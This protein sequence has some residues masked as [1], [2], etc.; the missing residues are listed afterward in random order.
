VSL[1]FLQPLL[2]WGAGLIAVPVVIHLLNRRR[3]VV[4][5]FAAMAFLEQAFARRRRRMRTENLLLLLLRCLVLLAAALA[6]ALPQAG[7][8]SPLAL[9]SGGRRELVLIVD[10]SGS[11][12][13]RLPG[14]TSVEGRLLELARAELSGLSDERGDAVTLV[15]PGGA[16]LLPAAIG[17]T[18]GQALATL[19]AGLPGPGGVAD[20]LGAVRLV[21]DRVRPLRPGH[22]DMVVLSD[23]QEVSWREDMG[24]LFQEIMDNGGGSLRVVDVAADAGNTANLGVVSLETDERLVLVGKPATFAAVV[25]N[26]GDSVRPAVSGSFLL[27]GELVRRVTLDPLPPRGTGVA[28]LRLRI[29]S[30]GPHHVTFALDDDELL[31]DDRRSLALHVRP[32]ISVLLVDGSHGASRLDRATG[33]LELALDPGVVGL[34]GDDLFSTGFT[35]RV[36][37][38]RAFEE[39]GRELFDYDAIVMAD[40]GGISRAA[41]ETLA[42]V[43]GSGTPLLLF[44]GENV[45]P[46]L[47][48]E[49][50]GELGLLPARV[51]S[52]EGEAAGGGATDYVTLVLADPPP[53]EL[54]LFA[55]PRLAVLL[56]V[57]VTRWSTLEPAEDARVLG[58][59]ADALG[60]TMP[61][62]VERTMGQGRVLLVGTSADDSWSLLPRQP[63]TWVPLV[64]ELLSSLAA[65][66][67]AAVNVPLGQSPSVVVD[68]RPARARLAAPDG[69]VEELVSPVSEE[70]GERSRLTLPTPLAQA[71]EWMLTVESSDP[72]RAPVSLALSALP[73]A[74]EGDL[75]RLDAGSLSKR[76]SGVE[77]VLGEPTR[78]ESG[79]L[80]ARGGDGSLFRALLWAL[81]ILAVGESLLARFV[82]RAR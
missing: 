72:T 37:D 77:Y 4:R 14:S 29:D 34:S 39:A 79:E 56:Q 22:L 50:L 66:D 82:G 78:D 21:R 10:R 69:A 48:D 35:S 61:A 11:T 25:A 27:D 64:H 28:S 12:A 40:V 20:L 33:W 30:P 62:I 9:L 54:A 58:Y 81:L 17:A 45:V 32:E 52:P 44:T 1:S 23:L 60:R 74:R 31:L 36:V 65:D 18:P 13:R 42:T 53:P 16:T 38:V 75:S 76:L 59:F 46:R 63:A 41:A 43:V 2:L 71:G 8:D 68:G 80:P 7:S 15:T 19:D 70:M 73:E 5:P 49:R 47:W 67:P 51:G 3:Y 26:H 24:P 57:P 55:D 6:M